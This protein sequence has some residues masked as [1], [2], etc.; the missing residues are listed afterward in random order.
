MLRPGDPLQVTVL[1][2]GQAPQVIDQFAL[3]ARFFG[4]DYKAGSPLVSPGRGYGLSRNTPEFR[5]LLGLSQLILEPGDP[6]NY[7]PHY[8]N[9]LLSSRSTPDDEGRTAGPANVLVIGTSG[10]P[11]VP[12]MTAISLAR[13]AGLVETSK[14][15][16]DFGIP[17][18][19]VLIRSGAVEGVAQTRRF[20]D[21]TGGVFAAL[22]G[23]VRCDPGSRCTG[24]VL[25]DPTGYSCD[26]SGQNCKD[27]L[28]APRLSPPLRGQ[29]QRIT[30]PN[31]VA[32]PI[33]ARA[34]QSSGCYST[35]ASA[36]AGDGAGHASPGTSALLIPYLNR[37]G[38]HGFRNPQPGKPFNLDQ[39]LGNLIGRYFE[40]RGRELHFEACQTGLAD[41]DWIPQ[42]PSP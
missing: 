36:C 22:P 16:P 39:F 2:A 31:A 1:R 25:I 40:C 15:D 14:P 42:P 17:I 18:D 13:A 24:D 30:T 7:A 23:H 27:G 5:R 34:Q 38:Q 28:G 3:K 10:D 9:D 11:G 37:T 29:L 6:V 26:G 12:V 41:C 20:D 32:C 8:A 21:P 35:G 33:S 19:Q 4:V